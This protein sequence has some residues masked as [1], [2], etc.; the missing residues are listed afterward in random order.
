LE[1]EPVLLYNSKRTGPPG[2][3][4]HW[5]VCADLSSPELALFLVAIGAHPFA[6]LVFV[7]FRLAAFF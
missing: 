3:S 7:D 1:G 6:T 4:S 5:P 2:A